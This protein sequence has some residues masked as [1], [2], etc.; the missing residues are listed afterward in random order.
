MKTV[1]FTRITS[2]KLG[3]P[4]SRGVSRRLVRVLLLIS[5]GERE[6]M[7][8]KFVVALIAVVGSS[9][10]CF[11][12]ATDKASEEGAP[13]TTASAIWYDGDGRGNPTPL[14]HPV[15]GFDPSFR[16]PKPP[17]DVDVFFGPWERN[18]G[19]PGCYVK[20]TRIYN[21]FQGKEVEIPITVC[22]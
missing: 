17:D 3:E 10:A 8:V 5:F 21:P 1:D 6:S 18:A 7:S 4:S 15:P 13:T 9:A 14:D 20:I 19:T 11:A 12:P 16:P 2:W 22:P